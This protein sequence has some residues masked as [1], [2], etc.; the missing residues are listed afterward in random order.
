MSI[1][2]DLS[3]ILHA[4]VSVITENAKNR[5]VSSEWEYSE[6]GFSE[7][8]LRHLILNS[9]RMYRSKFYRKY[10]DVV[11][12]LDS[13]NTWRK[14]LFPYYKQGRKKARDNSTVP[15][16]D[17]FESYNRIIKEIDLIFPYKVL[18]VEKMEAD[19]IIASICSYDNTQQHI[20]VSADKD[21]LQ[22]QR[23]S[24]V[25]N[26]CTRQKMML[27][28]DNPNYNLKLHILCGDAGDG[29]P[30]ILSD[31]DTFII[32]E[33]RQGVMTQ[34]KK[35]YF[36]SLEH[37]KYSVVESRNFLRNKKLIDLSEIPMDL[38]KEVR[39]CYIDNKERN[40]TLIKKYFIKMQ[41]INLLEKVGE[42]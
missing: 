40:N 7:N 25:Y 30:N 18:K 3:A 20:I 19:D 41:L 37:D 13:G 24:N 32:K 11:L 15:W 34:K 5:N 28:N 4:S 2:I 14:D 12:C 10:G 8:M 31:D 27:E 6:N 23:Y 39:K 22:L 21:M 17:V 16:N 38:Q 36:M 26:Y 1:L 29:I 33:K 35:D 42:F 9:V